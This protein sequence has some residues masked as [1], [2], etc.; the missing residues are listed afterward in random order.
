MIALHKGC[1]VGVRR[2]RAL[3]VKELR[4]RHK[5]TYR[6]LHPAVRISNDYDR[7]NICLVDFHIIVSGISP[8]A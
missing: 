7:Q 8:F 4:R 3:H 6:T 5:D 1:E 2:E